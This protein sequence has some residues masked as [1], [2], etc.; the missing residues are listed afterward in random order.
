MATSLLLTAA[1][2]QSL[3]LTVEARAGGSWSTISTPFL[4]A[5]NGQCSPSSPVWPCDTVL[6]D[7][8]GNPIVELFNFDP[9]ADGNSDSAAVRCSTSSL[10]PQDPPPG[11]S[12]KWLIQ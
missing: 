2:G 10:F 4:C 1:N 11:G 12:Y 9:S 6:T 5:S 3:L 7:G 8:A